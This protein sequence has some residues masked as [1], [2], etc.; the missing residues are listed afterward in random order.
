V[1][2]TS[3][4]G[5]HMETGVGDAVGQNLG[6]SPALSWLRACANA[7]A[8][9]IVCFIVHGPRLHPGRALVVPAPST[10]PAVKYCPPFAFP[11]SSLLY[12]ALQPAIE[13]PPR[14]P[15]PCLS[16]TRY[17]IHS[18]ISF[19]RGRIRS[20]A[21]HALPLPTTLSQHALLLHPRRPRHWRHG[22]SPGLVLG[23]PAHLPDQVCFTTTSLLPLKHSLTT[24]QRW[25][26]PGSSCH[27]IPRGPNSHCH[28]HGLECGCPD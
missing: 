17:P 26:D 16:A 20:Q 24:K 21:P 19:N 23:R 4:A 14:L 9:L 22:R 11:F 1:G 5:S 2:K 10:R 27:L 7:A 15:C 6:S 12:T 28:Y 3:S 8:A 13:V 18:H 25:S